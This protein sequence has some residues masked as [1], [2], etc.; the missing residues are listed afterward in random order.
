MVWAHEKLGQPTHVDFLGIASE[1]GSDHARLYS[2][3]NFWIHLMG[4]CLQE[5]CTAS[6]N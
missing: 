3:W 6:A 1:G 4:K 2:W 5:G